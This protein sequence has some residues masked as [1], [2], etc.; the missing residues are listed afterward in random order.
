[1]Q[2]PRAFAGR[3]VSLVMH[4]ISDRGLAPKREIHAI[5]C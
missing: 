2:D 3:Y 4:E 1:M 5:Q